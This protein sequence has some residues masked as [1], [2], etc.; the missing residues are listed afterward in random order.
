[1][2]GKWVGGHGEYG[3]GRSPLTFQLLNE[4]KEL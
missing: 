4:E 2:E 1:M 3:E